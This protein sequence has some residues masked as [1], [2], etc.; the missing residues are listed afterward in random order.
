MESR[1]RF[2]PGIQQPPWRVGLSWQEA[3]L[4]TPDATRHTYHAGPQALSALGSPFPTIPDPHRVASCLV[5]DSIAYSGCKTL[6][7]VSVGI[8]IAL[9]QSYRWQRGVLRAMASPQP[10]ELI[11][12]LPLESLSQIDVLLRVQE[13]TGCLASRHGAHPWLVGMPHLR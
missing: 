6:V 1:C 7:P 5:L 11:L 3:T 4:W 8:T 9:H 10:S 12:W 2:R 13:D